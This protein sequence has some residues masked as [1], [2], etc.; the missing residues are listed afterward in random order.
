MKDVIRTYLVNYPD[1]A[2]LPKKY[3]CEIVLTAMRAMKNRRKLV[4]MSFK[5]AGI[6]PLD[7]NR[8]IESWQNWGIKKPHQQKDSPDSD[9]EEAA[10]QGW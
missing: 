4:R 1:C 8:V 10:Y 2:N 7:K 9:E 6:C 3:F 5:A